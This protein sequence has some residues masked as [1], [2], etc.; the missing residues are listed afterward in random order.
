M[1]VAAPQG[2]RWSHVFLLARYGARF[3]LRTG[4]GIV[5]LVAVLVFGIGTAAVFITPAENLVEELREEGD[6][7][8]AGE[9]I[10]HILRQEP[11]PDAVKWVV[12]GDAR[13][14]DYLLKDHPAVL[15]AIFLMLLVTYPFLTCF[16]AFNQ[17][18]GDIQ[19]RGLRY[20]LLR[21][22]RQNVFVGRLVGTALFALVNT[23]VLVTLLALYVGLRLGVYDAA[24]LFAWSLQGTVALILLS[25][26][27]IALCAWISASIDSPFASLVLC[28]LV[29]SFSWGFL[30]VLS[31]LARADYDAFVRAI[32]WGWKFDLLSVH[33]G[34]RLL[35]MGVMAA[36]T[37]LFTWLGLRTFRNRDL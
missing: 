27:Y 33:L 25:L 5:F 4:G 22:E 8:P 19:S 2:L 17:T 10:D 35:A 16:G 34:T 18:S 9:V 15:S 11:I 13:Q 1:P 23:A 6:D 20:L 32:P 37:A 24:S 26:P 30:G 36:Y 21:T 14:A 31:Q 3:A 12:G 29:T 28:L 7:R